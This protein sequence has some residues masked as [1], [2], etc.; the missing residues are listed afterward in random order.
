M[1]KDIDTQQCL[2]HRVDLSKISK[3]DLFHGAAATFVR[4]FEVLCPKIVFFQT[5]RMK[6]SKTKSFVS[7]FLGFES[8]RTCTESPG[9]VA[10]TL[11]D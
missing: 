8:E 11:I 4:I 10:T 3:S 2:K 9:L 5:G 1:G 6:G 7:L